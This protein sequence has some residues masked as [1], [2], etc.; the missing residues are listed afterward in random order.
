MEEQAEAC[1]EVL[2][3]VMPEGYI[4]LRSGWSL[5]INRASLAESSPEL[6]TDTGWERLQEPLAQSTIPH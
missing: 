1:Q 6:G 2:A 3:K 5:G 4:L